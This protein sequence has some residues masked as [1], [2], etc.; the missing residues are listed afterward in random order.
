MDLM[1]FR[2]MGCHGAGILTS[3]T[4]QNTKG[5]N[6]IQ[7][8]HPDLVWSQYKTLIEDISCAG[9]KIGMLGCIENLEVV[10]KILSENPQIPR[11]VDPVFKSS[12]GAWLLEKEHIH[13]YLS[14]I[15]EKAALITPNTDEA[16]MLTGIK[17]KEL[18]D[19]KNAAEYIYTYSHIPC[20]IKGGNFNSCSNDLFYDGKK[21]HHFQNKKIKKRVHGTGC[22]LSSSIL[23]FLAKKKSLEKACFLAIQT[24]H[25]AIEK[26]FPLGSG[27]YVISPL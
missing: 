3:V 5:I 12:S 2:R 11:V 18:T 23:G 10:R 24:T 4:A 16:F 8:L 1:V 20:L 13:R 19:M 21:F 22:F 27:Q 25:Q 17:I 26:A 14:K 9:I 7:C 6:R 15:T